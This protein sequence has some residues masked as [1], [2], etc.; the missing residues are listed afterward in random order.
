MQMEHLREELLKLPLEQLQPL[1][2][3]ILTQKNK[4]LKERQQYE[5]KIKKLLKTLSS[6]CVAAESQKN[7][8]SLFNLIGC[9]INEISIPSIVDQ[10]T[11]SQLISSLKT[12][13]SNRKAIPIEETKEFQTELR[14]AASRIGAS[15]YTPKNQRILKDR[16]ERYYSELNRYYLKFGRRISEPQFFKV[17]VNGLKAKEIIPLSKNQNDIMNDITRIVNT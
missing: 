6:L 11:V 17:I 9:D 10:L 13:Y 1:F 4:E 2:D 15:A 3:E 14:I 8:W 12:S 16:M 5:N 7:K